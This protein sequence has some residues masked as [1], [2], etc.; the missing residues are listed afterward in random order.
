MSPVH[1]VTMT[2][3]PFVQMPAVPQSE[4]IMQGRGPQTPSVHT[5]VP[6]QSEVIMHVRTV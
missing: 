2:Q 1:A 4:V 5:S 6:V 3:A